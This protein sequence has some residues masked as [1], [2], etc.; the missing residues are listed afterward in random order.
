LAIGD[1]DRLPIGGWISGDM[2]FV[3][4]QPSLNQQSSISES[5]NRQSLN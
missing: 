3:D 1:F 5:A 2:A 4:H